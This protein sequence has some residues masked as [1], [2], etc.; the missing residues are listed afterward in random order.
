MSFLPD[1]YQRRSQAKSYLK[2]FYRPGNSAGVVSKQEAERRNILKGGAFLIFYNLVE[3]AARLSIQAVHDQMKREQV[4]FEDLKE[5]IRRRVVMSFAKHADS[6]V[7][8]TMQDVSV[9]IVRLLTVED[10]FSGNVDAK[11]LREIF[12][13]YGIST[14]TDVKRTRNGSDLLTI[15]TNRNDLAHGNKTYEE[16]G[17]GYSDQDLLLIGLRSTRYIEAILLNVESYLKSSDFRK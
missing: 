10:H 14:S 6:D 12:T 1:F 17:R 11:R 15:K 16:V 5:T 9:E 4:S 7:H 8:H 13:M 2:T 3:A